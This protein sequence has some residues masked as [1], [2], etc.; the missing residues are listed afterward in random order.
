MILITLVLIGLI[1]MIVGFMSF[2]ML[3]MWGD[4]KGAPFVPSSNKDIT[5]LL[6][7]VKIKPGAMVVELGCGSGRFLRAAA[8]KYKI[9]GLGVDVN[10]LLIWWAR[11]WARVSQIKGLQFESRDMFEVN[12]GQADVVYLF[13][14]PRSLRKLDQKLHD[15]V[16]KGAY[17]ISHG[18]E[19][20]G[21][22]SKLVTRVNNHVFDSYVYQV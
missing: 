12:L 7:V 20:V 4:V 15:E 11:F 18:F 16:K 9:R 2:V 22:N 6:E 1:I 13:L 10:I 14:L 17:V 21:W 5:K 19:L 8:A 3:E